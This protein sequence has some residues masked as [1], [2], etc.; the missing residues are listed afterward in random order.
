MF[1]IQ[2]IRPGNLLTVNYTG[3]LQ[4]AAKWTGYKAGTVMQSYSARCNAAGTETYE[5]Q[6]AK[7]GAE[8]AGVQGWAVDA[9][10][11]GACAVKH[12][13]TGAL[14]VRT[15]NLTRTSETVYTLDGKVL[16][17][18]ETSKINAGLEAMRA[19]SNAAP[20]SSNY[21]VLKFESILNLVD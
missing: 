9:P 15:V 5:R 16:G 14:Y 7:N 13:Q 12:R 2:S 17:A 21:K 1:A 8:P 19:A 6:L 20:S 11:H 4:A 10:E 3:A 18:D